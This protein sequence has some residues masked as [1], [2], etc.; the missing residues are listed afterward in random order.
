MS[1]INLIRATQ[2]EEAQRL[3]LLA[4]D[5]RRL[6][7]RRNGCINFSDYARAR[8]LEAQALKL[9]AEMQAELVWH[10]DHGLRRH[11]I[12]ESLAELRSAMRA[13]DLGRVAAALRSLVRAIIKGGRE[14]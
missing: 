2:V 6:A 13:L 3:R 12:G 7:K 10:W 8:R 1:E 11:G 14:K 9:E 5:Y 4:H